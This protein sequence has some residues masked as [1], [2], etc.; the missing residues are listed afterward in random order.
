M[1]EFQ[2]YVRFKPLSLFA[3]EVETAIVKLDLS[4][5]KRAPQVIYKAEEIQ[6][7][8]TESRSRLSTIFKCKFRSHL[9]ETILNN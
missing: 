3:I 4:I 2:A 7:F 8:K 6:L 1:L 5:N 9:K